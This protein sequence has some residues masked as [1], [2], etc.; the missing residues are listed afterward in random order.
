MD[1]VHILV[2]Y[3]GNFIVG[4]SAKADGQ[5]LKLSLCPTFV[6]NPGTKLCTKLTL[7]CH[8]ITYFTAQIF[9]FDAPPFCMLAAGL[10]AKGDGQPFPSFP[11]SA[12]V[13]VYMFE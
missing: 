13:P 4:L 12:I 11:V 2:K 5:P 7:P 3:N 8:Q 1:Q 10:S 9:F 6:C